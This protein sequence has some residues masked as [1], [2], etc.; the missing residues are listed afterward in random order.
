MTAEGDGSTRQLALPF[1]YVPRF[2]V[3]DFIAAPSNEEAQAWLARTAHWPAGRLALYGEAG[4]GKTHLLQLWAERNGALLLDGPLLRRLPELAGSPAIAIDDADAAPDET[5]LLHLMNLAAEMR[6]PLLLV[7]RTPPARW[8]VTLPDLASRLRAMTAVAVKPAEDPLL[9][10]LLARLLSDRQLVLGESLQDWL[11]ARLP[12]HPAA[13][14]E[15][16][17]RLDRQALAAGGRVTRA[18]AAS[19]VETIEENGAEEGC[20]LS[21]KSF[22]EHSPN[23]RVLL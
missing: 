5:T 18:M 17:A 13:L 4:C 3:E 15:A 20:D 23:D 11:L 22:Q 1:A 19:L 9:R 7:G 21:N 2:R 6:R 10:A 16:A 8:R 12:R 14:R